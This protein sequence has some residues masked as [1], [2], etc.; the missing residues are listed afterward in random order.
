MGS[1]RP[2]MLFVAS[3]A[4]FKIEAYLHD[5][6]NM[7]EIVVEASS[8][9]LVQSIHEVFN[10]LVVSIFWSDTDQ[11]FNVEFKNLTLGQ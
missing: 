3:S 7:R 8:V 1:K 10:N 2:K 11:E 4:I 5:C 9:S 6:S